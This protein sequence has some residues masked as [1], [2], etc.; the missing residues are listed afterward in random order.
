MKVDALRIG[1]GSGLAED[2]GRH[3]F[4]ICR[5]LW[6]DRGFGWAEALGQQGFYIGRSR[7]WVVRESA[8]AGDLGRQG[9]CIARLLWKIPLTISILLSKECNIS[10]SYL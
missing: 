8:S 10:I 9:L 5:R 3:G 2:L 7:L 4:W 6:G 1:R